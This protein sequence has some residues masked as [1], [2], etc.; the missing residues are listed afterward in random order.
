MHTILTSI[1][2][3]SYSQRIFYFNDISFILT[4]V[5][6]SLCDSVMK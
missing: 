1:I 4:L 3:F 2:F 6:F 5:D